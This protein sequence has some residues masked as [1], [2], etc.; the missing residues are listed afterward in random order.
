MTTP[1]DSP[2]ELC[3]GC[4]YFPPNLPRH[5]YAQADWDMLQARDCS[6]AHQPGGDECLATRKTSC[7]LV[8]LSPARPG[9]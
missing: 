3:A 2:A 8:D 7:R 4:V 9:E 1:S 6:F 5:A